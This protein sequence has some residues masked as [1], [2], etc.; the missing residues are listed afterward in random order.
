LEPFA[1]SRA[2]VTNR[3]F[4]AFVEDGGYLQ[5]CLW[6]KEGSAWREHE[7]A[8]YPVYWRRGPDGQWQ[9][10]DFDR[11]LPLEP[12]HPVVHVCWYEADAYCRWAGRR[13]PTE[14]EWEAAAAGGARAGRKPVY[15]WG[16]ESP[17]AERAN[18]DGR[19]AGCVDVAA[20][21]KGD[22]ALGIRQMLGNVWEWTASDFGPYPG[23]VVDPYEEYS[24][25]WFSGHK[26]LR[27]GSWAT[28]GRLLRNTWRNFY[29]PDRRDVFAGFRTCPTR[30]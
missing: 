13:L 3:S 7:G 16:D 1:I 4:A 30:R 24:E 25:P 17:N 23:F 18:L 22:T 29:T 27:G 10:R 14:A 19:M 8:A 15:P 11:W 9:R 28:P 21:P 20:F 26:V 5:E 2:P 6:S 12:D